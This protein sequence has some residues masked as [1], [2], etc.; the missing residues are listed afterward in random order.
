[1]PSVPGVIYWLYRE[2]QVGSSIYNRY[3]G[4]D[5]NFFDMNFNEYDYAMSNSP[6]GDAVPIKLVLDE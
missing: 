5:M 4:W 2:Y 1:M 3:P 6:Y